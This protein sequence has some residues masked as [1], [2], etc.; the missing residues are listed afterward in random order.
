LSPQPTYT[1]PSVSLTHSLT[2]DSAHVHLP[3]PVP[4]LVPLPLFKTFNEKDVLKAKLD[5]VSATNMVD[6]AE[7]QYKK[8]NN[9]DDAPAEMGKQREQVLQQLEEG[10]QKTA[11][12]L[13]LAKDE[14]VA[15]E[16][17]GD[18]SFA[19]DSIKQ[20]HSIE[21]K[22]LGDLYDYAKLVYECGRYQDAAEYLYLFRQLTSDPERKFWA[23]WGK[24]AAN[25]LTSQWQIALKDLVALNQEID[26]RNK[27]DQL[28]Q[29]KQRTWLIHWSLFIYCNVPKGQSMLVDFLMTDKIL[30]AVQ[31]TSPHILRYLAAAAISS[32]A[33]NNVVRSIVSILRQEAGNHSDPI[34]EFLVS[35]YQD[36]DFDT[37]SDKLKRAQQLMGSDFF[38]MFIKGQ[39]TPNARQLMFDTVCRIHKRINTSKLAAYLG[40][41]DEKTIEAEIVEL[42]RKAR[43][44][45]RLDSN[46]NELIINTS[47]PATYQRVIDKTKNLM[48]RTN[49]MTN[50]LMQKYA[51]L[52]QAQAEEE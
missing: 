8:L 13:A 18:N 36:F 33:R 32:G 46:K 14:E 30:N 40:L 15:K 16:I 17:A 50:Q 3:L 10:K 7:E 9:T 41:D 29:L 45:A 26:A 20:Q 5:L 27:V 1:D 19:I 47:Y 43:V 12:V 23:L 37:A 35:M 52:E 4:V 34:T 31:T 21:E 6:F 42:L 2:Y 49:N 28:E 25:I 48:Y 44:N 51:I 22:E 11:R 38:L 39:F 24:L